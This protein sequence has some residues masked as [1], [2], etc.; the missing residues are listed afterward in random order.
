[1][2]NPLHTYT[3]GN[4]QVRIYP[5][6]TKIREGEGPFKPEYPESIDLKITNKCDMGCP[7]CHENSLPAGKHANVYDILRNLEG[8]PKGI[9]IA[10]G[11]G[12]PLEHSSITYLIMD[13][14]SRGFIPNITINAKHIPKYIDYI[15]L[16]DRFNYIYGIGVSWDGKNWY[17]TRNT[18][19]HMIVGVHSYKSILNTLESGRKVLLLGYKRKGRGEHFFSRRVE[20]RIKAVKNNL[21]ILLKKGGLSFDNLAIEQLDVKAH[22]AD[23]VWDK[24][25]MGDDGKFT[26]YYDAVEGYYAASSVS[27]NKHNDDINVKEYFSRRQCEKQDNKPFKV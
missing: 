4:Y 9:E 6:G 18:V 7:Y 24:Y 5:D 20:A 25:Y 11:G 27:N 12:N 14:H 16:I 22:L 3:N 13:L 26:M 23:N 17:D 10:I 2:K 19:Y 1:M 15:E 21:W 8:L